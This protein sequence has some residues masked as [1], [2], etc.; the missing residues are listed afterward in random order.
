MTIVF[1][2][3][4]LKFD[5]DSRNGKKKKNSEKVFVFQTI[6]F[7]LGVANSRNLEHYPW[8]RQSMC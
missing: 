3:K 8:H 4:H 5:V 6:P 7:E 1:F 2:S